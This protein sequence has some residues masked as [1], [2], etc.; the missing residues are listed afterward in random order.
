MKTNL[1]F[2]LITIFSLPLLKADLIVGLLNDF[3]DGTQQNW[4]PPKNNTT[5]TAGGPTG[6]TRFLSISPAPRI[7]AF[8]AAFAGTISSDVNNISV[9]MMRPSGEGVLEIRMA[10][11]GQ[12]NSDRWTST[13]ANTVVDDGVWRNYVFSILESDL[14]RVLGTDTYSNLTS[15]LSRFLF[16]F[17][18]G[19]PDSQGENGTGTLGIDNVT[20]NAVAVPEPSHYALIFALVIAVKLAIRKSSK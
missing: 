12:T 19:T 14:T 20:V 4:T 18:S 9:D 17:D 6:S 7:S 15:N 13:V 8:T 11:T 2:T 3:E 1:L 16:R 10:L 5:N